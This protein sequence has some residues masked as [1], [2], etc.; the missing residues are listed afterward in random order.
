MAEQW[1][2]DGIET[3][4]GRDWTLSHDTLT[5]PI[6]A[7]DETIDTYREYDRAGDF[8]RVEG[9]AGTWFVQDRADRDATTIEPPD[10]L[11]PAVATDEYLPQAYQEEQLAPD[12]WRVTLTLVRTE[13]RGD[14]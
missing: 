3:P 6:R 10:T 1:L 7:T 14:G 4:V 13:P 2:V 5:L 9:F 11:K 8:N 12:E